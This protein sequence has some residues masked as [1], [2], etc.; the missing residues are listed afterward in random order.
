ML[1]KIDENL[2]DPSRASVLAAIRRLLPLLSVESLA[3]R[4]WIVDDSGLRIRE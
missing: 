2:H 3:G 1:F 4:L